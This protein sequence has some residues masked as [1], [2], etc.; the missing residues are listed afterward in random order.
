MGTLGLILAGAGAGVA[1]GSLMDNG[2]AK[3]AVQADENKKTAEALPQDT[4]AS[5]RN[6]RLAASL[7][8]QGFTEPQLGKPGLQAANK[9]NV[10]GLTQ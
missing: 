7:M 1:A 6:K 9:A 5:K 8:T 10:L 3:P 4:E 2:T